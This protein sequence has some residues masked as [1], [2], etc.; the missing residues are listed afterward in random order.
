LLES[1]TESYVTFFQSAENLFEV[2]RRLNTCSGH[3]LVPAPAFVESAFRASRCVN[4]YAT[5]IRILEGIKE[6]VEN[7]AQYRAYMNEL[8]PVQEELGAFL[9]SCHESP[10]TPGHLTFF[11]L[12][13]RHRH[14]RR[15]V[16]FV[17][18]HI[19]LL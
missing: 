1:F 19:S 6:K 13:S 3:D 7:E 9:S 5:A 11:G 4:E 17:D 8:K 16:L 10:Y 2:Q 12:P 14:K 15:I 18:P